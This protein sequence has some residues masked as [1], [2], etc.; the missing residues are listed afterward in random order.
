MKMFP[1]PVKDRGVGVVSS[2]MYGTKESCTTARYSVGRVVL[3]TNSY[4]ISRG[5]NAIRRCQKRPKM[6]RY[7]HTK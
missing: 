1:P 7:H 3:V 2:S 6:C 5:Q 4:L